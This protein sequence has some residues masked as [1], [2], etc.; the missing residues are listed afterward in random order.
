MRIKNQSLQKSSKLLRESLKVIG[1]TNEALVEP[2][3]FEMEF[4]TALE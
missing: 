2:I 1:E 3:K 4:I